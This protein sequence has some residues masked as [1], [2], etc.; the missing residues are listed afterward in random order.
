[1]FVKGAREMKER[2]ASTICIKD[3][4]GSWSE[5][6]VRSG[7]RA[8]GRADL[9]VI[10]HTHCTTGLAFMTALKAAEAGVDVI[11][12]AVSSFSGGTSQ[13]RRDAGLRAAAAR[14]RGGHQREP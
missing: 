2:G 9:P 3:M 1:M 12:T 6:G 11:D 8:E 7:V 5:G 10:L 4:A 13:P 14:L